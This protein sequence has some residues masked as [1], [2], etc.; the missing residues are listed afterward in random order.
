MKKTLTLLITLL[1]TLFQQTLQITPL[2]ENPIYLTISNSKQFSSYIF[3]FKLEK[4]LPPFGKIIINFP[5]QY[6]E[7]LG[8]YLWGICNYPCEIINHSV[9]LQIE[10]GM[11]SYEENKIILEGIKNPLKIGGTGQFEVLSMFYED[12]LEEN[13]NFGSIG[14]GSRFFDILSVDVDFNGLEENKANQRVFYLIGFKVIEKTEKNFFFKIEFEKRVFGFPDE[15]VIRFFDNK[16]MEMSLNY[17]VIYDKLET[18]IIFFELEVKKKYYLE[19]EL[20]NPNY[21]MVF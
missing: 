7:N 17:E 16:E 9:I 1:T 6:Q 12:I 19:I 5:K 4:D 10:H 18:N 3:T 21:Q 8:I 2:T 13:K 20:I 14:I 11:E 15:K